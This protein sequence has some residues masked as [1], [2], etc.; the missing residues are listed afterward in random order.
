MPCDART[1]HTGK[2]HATLLGFERAQEEGMS[3]RVRVGIP[4]SI[5][6]AR[7]VSMWS[8]SDLYQ[9]VER[10]CTC[11]KDLEARRSRARAW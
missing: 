8:S 1:R 10:T 9:G 6:H 5:L 7:A 3:F 4:L 11:T 2:G